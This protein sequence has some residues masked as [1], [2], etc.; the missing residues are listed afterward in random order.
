MLSGYTNTQEDCREGPGTFWKNSGIWDEQHSGNPVLTNKHTNANENI[1]SLAEVIIIEISITKCRKDSWW[2]FCMGWPW[3]ATC[4]R[5][6]WLMEWKQ[7]CVFR[8]RSALCT[9]LR[10]SFTATFIRGFCLN[11]ATIIVIYLV[12]LTFW[13][14]LWSTRNWAEMDYSSDFFLVIIYYYLAVKE[15][16]MLPSYHQSCKMT[17]NWPCILDTIFGLYSMCTTYCRW[18]AW[19]MYNNVHS[20]VLLRGIDSVLCGLN[21]VL[22]KMERLSPERS[23]FLSR[24]ISVPLCNILYELCLMCSA[25][26]ASVLYISMIFTRALATI[27][28]W[29]LRNWQL[30]CFCSWLVNLEK[31]TEKLILNSV[32]Y[33]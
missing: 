18:V 13:E 15:L 2:T 32:F 29:I 8:R 24:K 21:S 17:F 4:W 22:V 14:V 27:F 31:L 3:T 23:D 12:L 6:C 5:H 30:G 7:D 16:F 1:T 25:V 33:V 10:A 28:L 11:T 20:Y 26:F 9:W 19:F